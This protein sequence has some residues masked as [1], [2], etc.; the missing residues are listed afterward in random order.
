MHSRKDEYGKNWRRK[1]GC[2][3]AEVD[4]LGCKMS[5]I[6]WKCLRNNMNN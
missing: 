2:G 5:Q 1:S 4:R 6:K 3:M